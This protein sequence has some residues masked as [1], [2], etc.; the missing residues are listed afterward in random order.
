LWHATGKIT[1]AH[2]QLSAVYNRFTEGFDTLDLRMA[3]AL[4]SELQ[5]ALAAHRGP[6]A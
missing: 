5:M 6:S 2:E 4:L 3:R 1:E